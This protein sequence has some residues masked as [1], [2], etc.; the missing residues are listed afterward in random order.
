MRLP[1]QKLWDHLRAGMMGR[2]DAQRH[3]DKYAT[4]IPDVSFGIHGRDGWMELKH[5]AAGPAR[6][7]RPW[8]FAID[9]LTSDQR[10]WMSRRALSG[11]GRVFLLAQIGDS[12]Y[13]WRWRHIASGLGYLTFSE[14]AAKAVHWHHRIAFHELEA[15][16]AG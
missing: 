9:H 5:L 2:W 7:D 14:L 15:H 10:N 4:G 13:L 12:Y 11:G 3:E 6:Q 8:D 16:L 1:E